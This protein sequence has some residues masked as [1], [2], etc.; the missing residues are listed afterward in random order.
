MSNQNENSNPK[1]TND[2]IALNENGEVV[3]K[4]PKLAEALQELSQEELDAIAGGHNGNC[5][6]PGKVNVQ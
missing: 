6:C 1:I 2:A 5:G 3:V 4:D